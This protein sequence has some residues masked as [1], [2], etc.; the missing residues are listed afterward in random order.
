MSGLSPIRLDQLQSALRRSQEL[1]PRQIAKVVKRV[2]DR[3]NAPVWARQCVA[4]NHVV[5][6]QAHATRDEWC[7]FCTTCGKDR[8]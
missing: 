6:L 7:W 2:L 3:G 1:T 4:S 5:T 8:P